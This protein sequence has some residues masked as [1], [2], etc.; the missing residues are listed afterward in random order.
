WAFEA[1]S[2]GDYTLAQITEALEAKGVTTRATAKV[3]AKPLVMRHVH[4]FLGNPFYVGLMSWGGVQRPGTHEPLIGVDTFAKV[5]AVM[6]SHRQG[7]EKQRKHNHYLKST[8]FCGRC[9]SRLCF[10]RSRGRHGVEYDY[11]FCIGRHQKRTDCELPAI[12]VADIEEAIEAYY[13]TIQLGDEAVRQLHDELITA[14]RRHTSGAEKRARQQRKR[15]T[16]LEGERRKLLQAY[17]AGAIELELLKEDQARIMRQLADAGAALA[18][19][20]V[21]WENIETNLKAAL[22]LAVNFGAAYR[23]AAPQTRR[24]LNQ[25]VFEAVYVDREGVNYTRLADPFSTL[26]A[27]DLMARLEQ[28]LKNPESISSVRGS[29]EN[30]LVEVSG[31]EPPTSTLRTYGVGFRAL[32]GEHGYRR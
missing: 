17:T 12:P 27:E 28:E 31:L 15:I 30:T 11:F 29:K 7:P 2:T 6:A 4:N 16:A 1:Y 25:A 3:S 13:E 8:V 26:L 14:M 9:Q 20:E 5:Q 22:G 19:T 24:H 18:A 23:R 21:H 10:G 32:P